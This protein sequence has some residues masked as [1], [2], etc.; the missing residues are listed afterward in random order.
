MNQGE[1]NKSNNY[2]IKD[3]EREQPNSK[4]N[5]YQI[6]RVKESRNMTQNQLYDMVRGNENLNQYEKKCLF[7]VLR[8][9]LQNMTTKPGK[10]NLFQ[11]KF[12]VK[13]DKAI[14]GYSRLIPFS[15]RPA[16]REQIEQMINDEVLELS[17]SQFLNPLTIV[18]RENKKPRICVD[19]RKINQVTIPDYERSSPMQELLQIFE[20]TK[21]MSTIDLSSAYLQI[22]LHP[23]SRKY[24]AF[25]FD[26]TVYQFKRVPY[27]FK[28]SLSA[29]V[30]ALKLALGKDSG[31]YVTF[32][33]DD[34]IVHSKTFEEHLIHLNTV[35]GKLCKA[36]FTLNGTLLTN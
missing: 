31:S 28:N 12:Q 36:G 34:I 26:T 35:I 25:L 1:H 13:T 29:F 16:V 10:C 7:N 15:E 32:Y 17:D 4:L 5:T 2:Q 14:V 21:Y 9:Y 18:Q 8:T 22:E 20:G 3:E 6:T 19:A 11:Y 33:V 30:T 24:T 23:D 27:G